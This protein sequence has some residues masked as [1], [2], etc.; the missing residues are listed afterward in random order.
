MVHCILMLPLR[1]CANCP[2][3]WTRS[4]WVP[5]RSS[6]SSLGLRPPTGAMTVC[7]SSPLRAS[8]PKALPSRRH[9]VHELVIVRSC[10]SPLRTSDLW[11]VGKRMQTFLTQDGWKHAIT[12]VL[13][14]VLPDS[15]HLSLSA[16][17]RSRLVSRLPRPT[18]R[19]PGFRG[20]SSRDTPQPRRRAPQAQPVQG[21][22]G[23]RHAGPRSCAHL[24]WH[25]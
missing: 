2:T 13:P 14:P 6:Q 25:G 3:A 18:P 8:R 23:R 1:I 15:H 22:C 10:T 16:S 19:G 21:R 4:A 17:R 9:T 20:R 12:R 11:P 5:P 24:G 7:S